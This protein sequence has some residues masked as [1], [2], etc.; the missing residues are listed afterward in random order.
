MPIEIRNI[1]TNALIFQPTSEEK[2][3]ISLEKRIKILE[4]KIQKMELER[5][6]ISNN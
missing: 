5:N 2:K 4:N 6:G 3:I 1:V